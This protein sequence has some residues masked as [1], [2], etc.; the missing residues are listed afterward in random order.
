MGNNYLPFKIGFIAD[1]SWPLCVYSLFSFVEYW[2]LFKRYK[3]D[4]WGYFSL[5]GTLL[6]YTLVSTCVLVL[7]Y[8]PHSTNLIELLPQSLRTPVEPEGTA[9]TRMTSFTVGQQAHHYNDFVLLLSV[10]RMSEWFGT[11][12]LVKSSKVI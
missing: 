12:I 8:Q 4:A 7:R 10:I 9:T 5:T 1:I 2:W 3:A 6:A 11:A